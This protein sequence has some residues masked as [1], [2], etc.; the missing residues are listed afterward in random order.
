VSEERK[1]Y[2]YDPIA[3]SNVSTVV[4]QYIPDSQVRETTY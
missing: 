2:Q 3:V 1:P 4:A